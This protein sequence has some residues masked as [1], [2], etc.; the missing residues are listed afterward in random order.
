MRKIEDALVV[1]VCVD[2]V[3]VTALDAEVFEEHLCEG[4]KAV[5]RARGVRDDVV[6]SGVVFGIVDTHDDGL[7][8]VLTG[9]GDQHLLGASIKMGLGLR[10]VGEKARRLD[11]NFDAQVAPREVGRFAVGQ[12]LD[13]LAVGDDAVFSCLDNVV[14]LAVNGIVFQKMGH[15]GDVA[16]VVDGNDLDFGVVRHNAICETPDTAETVDSYLDRHDWCPFPCGI[17]RSMT[18]TLYYPN[19]DTSSAPIRT[20][21]SRRAFTLALQAL[22]PFAR[23]CGCDGTQLISRGAGSPCHQAL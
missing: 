8:D 10:A 7:V 9:G 4:G 13:D 2:G 17:I 6:G 14:G 19:G 12:D 16:Q 21:R 11:D 5:R 18:M 3:H 23:F 1:R 22:A 15:R 20:P